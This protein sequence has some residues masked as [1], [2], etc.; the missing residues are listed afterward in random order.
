MDVLKS[1]SDRKRDADRTEQLV[2]ELLE[3]S[4][5][6]LARLPCSE[7][8]RQEIIETQKIK[9]HGARRRQIKHVAKRLRSTEHQPLID[10]LDEVKGSRLKE[11]REFQELE[12]LRNRICTDETGQALE[13]ISKLL[14]SVSVEEVSH[15]AEKYR[16]TRDRRYS[17]R[18]FQILR[19]AINKEPQ[20]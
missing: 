11:A 17:K 8:L 10:Y 16:H 12:R 4:P 20:T 3:L 9:T 13:E 1:K 7:D 19:I 18:I 5:V 15:L 6:Q 14:P 2:E